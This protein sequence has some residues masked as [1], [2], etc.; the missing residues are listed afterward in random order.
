MNALFSPVITT[1]DEAQAVL[2][3]PF[4]QLLS[5]A[6][7]LRKHAFGLKVELCAII[8]ARS[9]HCD[10]NCAFCS[11]SRFHGAAAPVFDLLSPAELVQR[12]HGLRDYPLKR[13]GIVTSGGALQQEDVRSL[14]QA[15]ELLATHDDGRWLGRVCGSLGRLPHEALT[16]LKE[17]GLTRYHHNLECSEAYYPQVC[18]TQKWQDRLATVQRAQNVG[19]ELCAGGLFGLGESWEDR[20]AF[21]LTLQEQGISHVPMNFLY[22]HK[23]TPL[24]H[25]PPL[26]AEDAL[27]IIALF[28]HILPTATLRICGGRPHILG[29]RQGEI[30]AAGANA[31]MTGDYLTT[32]GKGVEG[33]VLMIEEQGLSIC[34]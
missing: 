29:E 20:I 17:A 33:D 15:L 28:R 3:L 27:R 32:K 31:L 1:M 34:V 30:F 4:S 13:V 14:V 16:Y 12:L 8:N 2:A 11:Q 6:E 24:E 22:A 18:T 9:G 19:L 7:A 23:G 21:A 26:T 5:Q 25:V 10:M